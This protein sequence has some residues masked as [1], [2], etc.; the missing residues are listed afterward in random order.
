[1]P[2]QNFFDYFPVS[3]KMTAWGIY[4]T[5]FGHVRVPANTPYPPDRHP[6][7]HHFAWEKGRTLNEYQILYIHEGRG[8]FESSQT[9]AKKVTAGMAFLLFPG[10]WHRYRPIAATGWTESWIEVGGSYLDQLVAKGLIDPKNPVYRVRLMR[11][12]QEQL[13]NAHYLARTKPPA[14]PVQLGLIAVQILTL[15]RSSP[16]RRK[17][18]PRRMEGLVSEAQALLGQNL[19]ASLTAE[20]IAQKLGIGY[21][22]FRREF[23]RQ[24]GFSPKQYRIE[25]RH[26]R[27]KDMLRNSSMTV[28]EISERLGYHSPYHLSFDFVQRSGVPPTHWRTHERK[29]SPVRL[30]RVG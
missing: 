7:G 19:E 22:Y 8:T 20:Q 6:L 24:T 23:K 18:P 29:Q 9:D 2:A 26:R 13:D 11:E 3:S 21:S 30:A 5:S 10:V 15:F 27:A 14:F 25:I 28:K 4:A 1:M 12:V 17:A 16:Q